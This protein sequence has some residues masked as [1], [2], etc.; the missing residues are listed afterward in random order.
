[1]IQGIK[2]ANPPV[3]TVQANSSEAGIVENALQVD[4]ASDQESLEDIFTLN[5]WEALPFNYSGSV[6]TGRCRECAYLTLSKLTSN[7]L[8]NQHMANR[9]D[10]GEI[11]SAVMDKITPENARALVYNNGHWNPEQTAERIFSFAMTIS[12]SDLKK[13]DMIQ[14][15]II[16]GFKS[17]GE[18]FGGK[19]PELSSK[20]LTATIDRLRKWQKTDS[21]RDNFKERTNSI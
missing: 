13:F 4:A 6:A 2:S 3:E 19:L 12:G 8:R 21:T 17:A 15:S 5:P 20:T 14:E 1:M 10:K 18:L 7:I 11:E 9:I 16:D